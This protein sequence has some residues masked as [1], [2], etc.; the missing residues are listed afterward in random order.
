MAPKAQ[1]EWRGWA[2][3]LGSWLVL[4]FGAYWWYSWKGDHPT[5]RD[6]TQPIETRC[7]F[8]TVDGDSMEASRVGRLSGVVLNAGGLE[9]LCK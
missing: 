6:R 5:L 2:F 7:D 9:Y 1:R 4:G 3:T 8:Y